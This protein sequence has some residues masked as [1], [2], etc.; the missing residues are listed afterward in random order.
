MQ[1]KKKIDVIF[2]TLSIVADANPEHTSNSEENR[3]RLRKNDISAKYK[4]IKKWSFWFCKLLIKSKP[5]W[6]DIEKGD[7]IE[8]IL[9][10]II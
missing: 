7:K 2:V 3:L 1:Q 5:I 9:S 4:K 10:L 8:R 6:I